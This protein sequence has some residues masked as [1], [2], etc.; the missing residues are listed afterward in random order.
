MIAD[1]NEQ[2]DLYNSSDFRNI[3]DPPFIWRLCQEARDMTR[4]SSLGAVLLGAAILAA[5]LAA[6]ADDEW[7]GRGGHEHQWREHGWHRD[8]FWRDP[9]VVV[10]PAYAP[11]PVIYAPPIYGR[12]IYGQ[13]VYAPPAYA[14]PPL[15]YAPPGISLGINIPLH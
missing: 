2:R 10:R 8:G 13:P 1:R 15:I 7:R 3:T 14:P 5:P 4:I 9:V 6:R 12:P 11:P